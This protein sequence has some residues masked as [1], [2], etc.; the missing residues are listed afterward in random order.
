MPRAP[1]PCRSLYRG[2]SV[3]VSQALRAPSMVVSWLGCVVLRHS[4]ASN[5]P[6][7]IT[8]HLGV[9]QYKILVASPLFQS[10]YTQCIVIQSLPSLTPAPATIHLGVLQYNCPATTHPKPPC[11]DTM[12]YCNT[13][14][15]HSSPSLA[16]QFLPTK[17]CH[18]TIL[19]G[20]NPTNF[21]HFF[22]SFFFIIFFFSHTNFQLLE[23]TKKNIYLYFFFH[24]CYWKIQK[25]NIIYIYIYIYIILQYTLVNL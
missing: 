17:L 15:S 8:I 5:S 16:M 11:H 23:N 19:L 3:A 21:L 2:L 22:F 6:P 12:V 1:A 14:S 13:P 20:S 9:L 7:L 18:N 10:R 4:S 24:L 25:T